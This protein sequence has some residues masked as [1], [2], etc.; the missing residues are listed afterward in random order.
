MSRL[1]RQ[2]LTLLTTATR[3]LLIARIEIIQHFVG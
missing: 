1:K 3:T 2:F